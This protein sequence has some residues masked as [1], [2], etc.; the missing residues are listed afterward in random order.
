MKMPKPIAKAKESWDK[1]PKSKKKGIIIIALSVLAIIVLAI[2]ITAIINASK[3]GYKVLYSGLDSQETTEV[4][5]AL[6]DLGVSTEMNNK[7]EIMVPTEQYDTLLLQLAAQ[8]YPQSAPAYDIWNNSNSMTATDTDKKTAL[9]Y[10]LQN[11]LQTTLTRLDGVKSAIVNLNI[12][13]ESNYVWQKA[14]EKSTSTASVTLTLDRNV[15]LERE[16][17]T[18]IKN[19]VAFS[20]PNL[21]PE[22]VS[23]VDAG[24]GRELAGVSEAGNYNTTDALK[25]EQMYQQQLEDNVVRLLSARYGTGNVV[26]VARVTLDFDKMMEERKQLLQLENG[27]DATTHREQH[28]SINGTIPGANGLVGEE[29]NT[30]IPS[31]P[32][33]QDPNANGGVT[34]FSSS[35][36]IDYGY[37]LTQIEK[38]EAEIESATISVMV[39]DNNLDNAT[40]TELI[41]QVSKS[42][43]IDPANISLASMNLPA[44][45]VPE[46]PTDVAQGFFEQ[47]WLYLVIAGGILLLIIAAV[48]VI[49]IFTKRRARRLATQAQA[50]LEEQ[51]RSMEEEMDAY[52]R[53]LEATAK[54]GAQSKD[55]VIV[56]EVRGFAKDNPEITASLIRSW[57]KEDDK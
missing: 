4:H 56:D 12:P 8:G 22:K 15:T 2:V 25:A 50:E 6:Q 27:D 39:N 16:Q 14:T 31:Y 37:V 26:A 21:E 17:V 42:T 10:Q 44:D 35:E 36:D 18:A 32:M 28:Y 40:R 5:A 45:N 23:V 11:R 53:Q 47:Y 54:A 1:Q 20:T 43:N 3:P 7:G 24:T 49:I 51:Q 38:G 30:D 19:L 34:N 48:I 33:D 46:E 29:N 57:L 52:R 9:V 13:E 41:D 55:T